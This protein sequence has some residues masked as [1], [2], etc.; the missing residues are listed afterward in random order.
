MPVGVNL[1][2]CDRDVEP[3]AVGY[4]PGRHQQHLALG[5]L[6]TGGA[7][8]VEADPFAA[9]DTRWAVVPSRRSKRSWYSSV[10]RA[11]MS[12]SCRESMCLPRVTMVRS[13]P[14][15]PKMWLISA[16][17]YPPPSTIIDLGSLPSRITVSEVRQETPARPSMDGMAGREPAASTNRSAR[18]SSPPTRSTRGPVNCASPGNTSMPPA[19]SSC[20]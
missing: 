6:G 11:R 13:V 10:K 2:S 19:P 1:D 5:P 17:M 20:G 8:Q 9:A 7:R 16:A 18:I 3:V 15:E 14:S 4:P 12:V